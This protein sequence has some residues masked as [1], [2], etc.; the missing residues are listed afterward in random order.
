MAAA[1]NEPGYLTVEQAK[2]RLRV[3]QQP[4]ELC[5]REVE[6]TGIATGHVAAGHPVPRRV[7]HSQLGG[8]G[9]DWDE[10]DVWDFLTSAEKIIE[11]PADHRMS[12][13]G[14]CVAAYG[15]YGA[16]SPLRWYAFETSQP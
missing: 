6:N 12:R 10:Q 4:C 14:H 3:Y 15:R 2:A 11:V 13:I 8:L 7:C 16:T 5:Q 9:A 1:M